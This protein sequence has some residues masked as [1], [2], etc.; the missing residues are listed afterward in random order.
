MQTKQFKWIILVIG[1]IFCQ[2]IMNSLTIFYVDILGIFLVLILLNDT[3][4]I[5]TLIVLS[6]LADLIGHWYLGTH[7]FAAILISFITGYFVHFYKICNNYQKNFINGIVYSLLVIIITIIGLI[8]H[9]SSFSWLSYLIEIFLIS[10]LILWILQRYI[11][12][13]SA[14][15]VL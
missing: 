14:D 4:Q 10:P 11:I 12:R 7:L 8:T 13:F 9:N 1:L 15:L 6:L 3:Y 2:L 5:R